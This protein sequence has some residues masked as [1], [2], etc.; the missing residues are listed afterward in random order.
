MI[1]VDNSKHNFS[2]LCLGNTY[3][4]IVNLNGDVTK[5]N[6]SS[7]GIFKRITDTQSK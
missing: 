4:I 7:S 1:I 3:S 2:K 6:V 5:N